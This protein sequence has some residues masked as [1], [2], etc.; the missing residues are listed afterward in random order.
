[1]SSARPAASVVAPPQP[2]IAAVRH[3]LRPLVKLLMSYGV[4]YP[5]MASLLKRAYV[6]V[7]SESFALKDKGQTDSRMTLLTG[8]HRPDIKRL[9]AEIAADAPPPQAASLGGQLLT[10]WT[11]LPQYLESNGYPV[12]LQK[13]ASEGG[14]LS[15]EHLVQSVSKDFRPR[16]VLDEWLR[17]GIAKLDDEDRVVLVTEALI[18]PEGLEEMLSHF[19]ASTHDYLAVSSHNLLDGHSPMLDRYVHYDRLS[20][21]SLLQLEAEARSLATRAFDELNARAVSLQAAD[22]DRKDAILSISFG[23]YFYRG[24]EDEQPRGEPPSA[25]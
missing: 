5:Y 12:P 9:R 16:V 24:G 10:M 25:C 7:A 19:G 15:F 2:L 20:P 11:G 22:A 4:Q 8:I 14:E 3:L 1:M 13:H 6:E 18:P 23:A 17:L 21:D